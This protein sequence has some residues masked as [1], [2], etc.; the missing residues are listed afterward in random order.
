MNPIDDI[1]HLIQLS[2]APVFLLTGVGTLLN[3]LSGR[4][5][6]IID[7]A[8]ALEQQL[9]APDPKRTDAIVNELH[10]LE[11]RGRLIYHAIKLSTS[12]ALLVCFLIAALFASSMLHYSTRLI[13]SSLFIAAML[14]SIVSLTLFLREVYFA[15]ETF[16]IG[17]PSGKRQSSANR[18][19]HVA[20]NE[21]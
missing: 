15:I 19:T 13:V 4:L 18:R 17:L 1:A 11:R 20:Q 3:V 16:E 5:A 21:S 6:R 2:I 8:R 7:R 14:A 12:S 10:V 9:E